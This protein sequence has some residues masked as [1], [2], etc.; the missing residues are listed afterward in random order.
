MSTPSP[1]GVTDVAARYALWKDEHV[2]LLYDWLSSRTKMWP[3][4]AVQWGAAVRNMDAR[5]QNSGA[6][7]SSRSMYL[8]ERTGSATDD[9]D[10]LLHYE[11]RVVE[12]FHNKQQE[13]A[14]PWVEESLGGRQGPEFW[15]KKIIVHPGEVNKIKLLAPDVVVTHTDSPELYVWDMNTQPNRSRAESKKSYSKPNCILTGHSAVAEYG[16]SVTSDVGPHV[17]PDEAFVASGG[18]DKRVLVW[19]LQDYQSFGQKIQPN[20]ELGRPTINEGHTDTVEDVSFNR[21]DHNIL[22]SVGLDENLLLWDMRTPARPTSIVKKAHNGDINCCDFGGVNPN[23]IV[24]GGA[25]CVTTVWDTRRLCNGTGGASPRNQMVGHLGEIHCVAWNPFIDEVCASGGQDSHVNV[26]NCLNDDTGPAKSPKADSP[27]LLFRHVGHALQPST[28]T[29]LE[30]QPEPMDPW[31][32][33]SISER[34][35]DTGGSVL[36]IWR[37]A[38]LVRRTEEEVSSDLRRNV[39]GN[40]NGL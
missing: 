15:L 31:C 8:G 4:A 22:A 17:R 29:D 40:G 1:V 30:W 25:D 10:T 38:D 34:V 24:T 21:A 23:L 19:K 9:P 26:W 2:P 18:K 5:G 6:K 37:I 12:E 33:A 36:Q 28:V 14:S 39:N 27:A 13:I 3:H 11:V 16:L 7:Y 35:G 32:I 20:T